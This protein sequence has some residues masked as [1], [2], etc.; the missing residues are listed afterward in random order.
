MILFYVYDPFGQL[1]REN[2]K[3]LDKTYIYS[4][5]GIGNID[6]IKAYSYTTAQTPS[7]TPSST[8]FSYT[9]D[10]L[11]GFNGKSIT[12]NSN[13]GIDTYDGKTFTWNKG[14]LSRIKHNLGSTAKAVN[15]PSIQPSKTYSYTYNAFGQRVSASYTYFYTS[16]TLSPIQS[17]EVTNYTKKFFY[18]QFGRLISESNSKTL[19][20]ISRKIR[21]LTGMP[22]T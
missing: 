18:D 15:L 7:G 2:N 16:G 12:Y 22:L 17:G 8:T 19:Y 14:K 3:S 6:S 21:F 10:K 13:G 1:I 9:G 11:T 5:N 4:Y 20:G